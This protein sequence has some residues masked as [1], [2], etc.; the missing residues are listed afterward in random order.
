[1][2]EISVDDLLLLLGAKEAELFQLRRQLQA[3]LKQLGD[4]NATLAEIQ[5]KGTEKP[6][7]ATPQ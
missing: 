1:M 5:N 3:A 7:D 4:A 6:A 2:T